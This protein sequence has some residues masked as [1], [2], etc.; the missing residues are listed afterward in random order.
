MWMVSAVSYWW[1]AVTFLPVRGYIMT[2]MGMSMS[3]QPIILSDI[4]LLLL[5]TFL[6]ELLTSDFFHKRWPIGVDLN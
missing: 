6:A 3:T 4:K 5:L 2:T 1:H